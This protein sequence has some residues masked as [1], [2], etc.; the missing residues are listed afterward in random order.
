V[1]GR[2]PGVAR[3]ARNVLLF[4]LI[5]IFIKAVD[6]AWR[7]SVPWPSTAMEF[8]R[9]LRAMQVLSLN[10]SL[11]CVTRNGLVQAR[12]FLGKAMRP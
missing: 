2:F 9:S 7:G 4:A 11:S 1:L 12:A 6:G 3:M 10:Q 8:E 5:V